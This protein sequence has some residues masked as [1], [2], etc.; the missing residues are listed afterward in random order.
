MSAILSAITGAGWL[1][2]PARA[3]WISLVVSFALLPMCLL[4]LLNAVFSGKVIYDLFRERDPN[5]QQNIILAVHHAFLI[6]HTWTFASMVLWWEPSNWIWMVMG[7]YLHILVLITMSF[8]LIREVGFSEIRLQHY[9]SINLIE[10]FMA[11][12]I[13]IR[14]SSN[15][16]PDIVEIH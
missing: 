2:D 5:R 6:F 14:R 9:L 15:R 11:F 8:M 7:I 1:F 16:K 13:Y 3:S 12:W 4:F 10:W